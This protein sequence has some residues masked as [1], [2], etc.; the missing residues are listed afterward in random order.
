[1]TKSNVERTLETLVDFA[2]IHRQSLARLSENIEALTTQM[3]VFSENM[4][5]IDLQLERLG[6]RIERI[7]NTVEQQAETAKVQSDT[8]NRLTRLVEQLIARN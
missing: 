4:T 1:M 5:R 2:D 7:A 6:D 8:V 3:G